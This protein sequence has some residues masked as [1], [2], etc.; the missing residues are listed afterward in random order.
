MTALT[1]SDEGGQSTADEVP[2][3]GEP[4]ISRIWTATATPEGAAR[5]AEHFQNQVV[6][7]LGAIAGYQGAMLL[8]SPR[9]GVVDLIV[10]SFWTSEEAIRQFAGSDVQRAVIADDARRILQSYDDRVRHYSV[11]ARDRLNSLGSEVLI[12]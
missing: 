5:Y 12:Q 4:M 6:P 11:V 3:T 1:A 10:A 7:A 8:Q 9:N 2:S